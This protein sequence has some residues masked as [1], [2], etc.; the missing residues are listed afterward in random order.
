M[1]DRT[2]VIND[3]LAEYVKSVE[4]LVRDRVVEYIEDEQ[5][6]PKYFGDLDDGG[7]WV[8]NEKLG[9]MT[10]AFTKEIKGLW[11][12]HSDELMS[13]N[14]REHTAVSLDNGLSVIYNYL[15]Y[16]AYM[17]FKSYAVD[18]FDEYCEQRRNIN[19]DY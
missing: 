11:Y 5:Q 9:S 14:Y 8:F 6:C 1:V 7:T 13:V 17:W 18:Y 3:S 12:L 4:E 10:P 16:K 15:C 2:V 19:N